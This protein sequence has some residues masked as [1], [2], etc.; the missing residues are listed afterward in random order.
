MKKYRNSVLLLLF[1]SGAVIVTSGCSDNDG[2]D[3]SEIGGIR[4]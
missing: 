4:Y 3:D 2:S 1:I